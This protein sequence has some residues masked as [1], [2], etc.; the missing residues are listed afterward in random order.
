MAAFAQAMSDPKTAPY[1][2]LRQDDAAHILHDKKHDTLGFV[3]FEPFESA[4]FADSPVLAVNRPCFVMTHASGDGL[5]L[6]I[7]DPAHQQIDWATPTTLSVTL[8]GAWHLPEDAF[9]PQPIVE[10]D[11]ET[12]SSAA[13]TVADDTTTLTIN[14]EANAVY[15][16]RLERGE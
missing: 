3:F 7:S 10:A 14:G 11:K 1:R 13:A 12:L 8:A 9:R 15:G 4:P 2:V 5:E 6:S 16:F